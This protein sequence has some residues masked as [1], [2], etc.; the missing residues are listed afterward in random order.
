VRPLLLYLWRVVCFGQRNKCP[1]I[2][3][4]WQKGNY[5]CYISYIERSTSHWR[6]GRTDDCDK[7]SI[8]V[9]IIHG[10]CVAGS[11]RST[12]AGGWLK[13]IVDEV[14][15]ELI[16]SVCSPIRLQ[17]VDSFVT[18][19][20]VSV[21]SRATDGFFVCYLF[22]IEWLGGAVVSVVARHSRGRGLNPD[23]HTPGSSCG[24]VGSKLN[25]DD[26]QVDWLLTPTCPVRRDIWNS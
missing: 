2:E 4:G 6:R 8:C 22:I 7:L 25:F 16:L 15:L 5:V 10:A 26:L 20:C 19:R 18:S 23:C 1:V 17:L 21:K 3:T 24:L 14:V 13:V 9:T 11:R 12:P